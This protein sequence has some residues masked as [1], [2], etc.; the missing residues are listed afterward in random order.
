[1]KKHKIDKKDLFSVASF[2]GGRSSALMVIFMQLNKVLDTNSEVIFCNTGFEHISTLEFVR[3]FEIFTKIKITWLEFCGSHVPPKIVNFDNCSKNGEPFVLMCRE[4]K[5]LPNRVARFCTSDLKIKLIKRYLK[6]KGITHYNAFVGIRADEEHRY[7][8]LINTPIKDVFQYSFPLYDLG[9]TSA[10]VL[11]FWSSLRWDLKIDSR[12]GN[13]TLC[14][15]KGKANLCSAIRLDN[16]HLDTFLELEKEFNATF[17][18]RYSLQDLK[19]IALSEFDF[20][21]HTFQDVDCHCNI[22]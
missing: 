6:S 21:A 8:K 7:H 16:N 17:S 14:F 11:S 5:M 12:L 19:I 22:D 4:R 1:M 13:C 3:D 10:Y 2:S 9:I 15:N 20:P 18:S